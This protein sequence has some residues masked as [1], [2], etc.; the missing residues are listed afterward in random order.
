MTWNKMTQAGIDAY[1]VPHFLL[2]LCANPENQGYLMSTFSQ[3]NIS[4]DK[5]IDVKPKNA[6]MTI[7]FDDK[8]WLV[9]IV[10][11]ASFRMTGLFPAG[12]VDSLL[13]L[14]RLAGI[15]EGWPIAAIAGTY[16][17]GV[18]IVGQVWKT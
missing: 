8:T 9:F 18:M 10:W 17:A 3:I 16:S 13:T 11:V 4:G 6:G 5:P 2:R 12:A 15:E 14:G 1:A 7:K